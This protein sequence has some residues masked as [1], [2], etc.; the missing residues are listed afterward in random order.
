MSDIDMDDRASKLMA[1]LRGVR[2]TEDDD[3]IDDGRRGKVPYERLVSSRAEVRA[4]KAQ[5]AEMGEGLAAVKTG[6]QAKLAELQT[7]TADQVRGIAS[8]HAED[9]Q[10]VDLGLSDPL[11]RSALR[12]AWEAAPRDVRGKNAVDWWS[13]TLTARAA[14][15][16]DPETVA[17]P[18]VPTVLS[19]YLP[20]PP[21]PPEAPASESR[22]T[23]AGPPT[24]PARREARGLDSV[25]MDQGFDAFLSGL[26]DLGPSP[27]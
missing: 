25:P 17:A 12:Q 9:L 2:P 1:K 10:L 14:H 24:A 27:G 21:A 7:A 3:D 23:I 6:Y 8:G 16:S 4:L 22:S 20:A 26:K 11:G 5:L 15:F 13:S 19:G 18:V